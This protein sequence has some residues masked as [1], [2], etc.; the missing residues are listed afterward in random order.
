MFKIEAND[1][2][3]VIGLGYFGLPLAVEF[4]KVA[5]TIGFDINQERIGE[6]NNGQ[7]RTLEVSSEEIAQAEQISFTSNIDDVKS[8]KVFIVTVPTPINSHKQPDLTPLIKASEAIG[9]VMQAGAVVIYESTVYPGAT[10]EVCV[11][12][13]ERMSGMSFNKDFY[14]G[15]SPERIIAVSLQQVPTVPAASRSRRLQK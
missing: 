7:D 8:C 5:P 15:Y 4:G 11:P 9:S 12:I 1:R 13:L 2:I 6:L 3:A 10:E 14:A